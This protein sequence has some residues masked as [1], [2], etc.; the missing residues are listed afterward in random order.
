V[1]HKTAEA[2]P[3]DHPCLAG[4]FPGNPIVPGTLILDR[5]IELLGQRYPNTRVAEVIN[6]KFIRPLLPGQNFEVVADE[7]AGLIS[8]ECVVGEVKIAAGKLVLIDIGS[9]P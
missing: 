8:F 9:N 7:K 3:D 2:I 4:H 1:W 6:A 5:V